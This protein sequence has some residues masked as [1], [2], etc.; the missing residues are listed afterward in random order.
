MKTQ[1]ENTKYKIYEILQDLEKLGWEYNVF[2]K[3]K[4][5]VSARFDKIKRKY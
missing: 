2:K 1:K 4:R 3:S 5:I